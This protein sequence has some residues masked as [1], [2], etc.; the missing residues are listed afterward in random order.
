MNDQHQQ[1]QE[2]YELYR[3]SNVTLIRGTANLGPG[4]LVITSKNVCWKGEKD[5]HKIT[6]YQIGLSALKKNEDQCVYCQCDKLP[7]DVTANGTNED[8]DNDDDDDDNNN[9]YHVFED[10]DY[11]ELRF[12]P[13]DLTKCKMGLQDDDD[14]E[15][16]DIDM[17][18]IDSEQ[19][20]YYPLTQQQLVDEI[21]A[22]LCQGQLLNPDPED[23]D[24]GN[25]YFGQQ[26]DDD[27]DDMEDDDEEY[28]EDEE[29]GGN[30]MH[31]MNPNQVDDLT[32]FQNAD[33]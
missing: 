27:D 17:M 5:H 24:E 12:I 25:L 4:E 30:D 28:D 7:E 20:T 6:F 23:D 2:E 26:E 14:D 15:D 29:E 21:Y 10:E 16:E 19:P 33:E 22:K 32:R 9:N 3:L 31:V 18:D 1:Q 8:D 13:S 11:T